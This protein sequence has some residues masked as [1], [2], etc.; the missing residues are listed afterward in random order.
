MYLLCRLL[1]LQI[2]LFMYL[3][4]IIHYFTIHSNAFPFYLKMENFY[5]LHFCSNITV[6]VIP[7]LLCCCTEYKLNIL[8]IFKMYILYIYSNVALS[9]PL[10]VLSSAGSTS[11]P[12]KKVPPTRGCSCTKSGPIPRASTRCSHST[13]SGNGMVLLIL[14]CGVS[15]VRSHM[16]QMVWYRML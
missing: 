14:R 9:Y 6:H 16:E 1:F 11:G 8:S 10:L 2:I 13:S 5:N 4:I 12:K 3:Y 15:L 7:Y